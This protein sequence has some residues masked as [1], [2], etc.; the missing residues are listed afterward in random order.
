LQHLLQE[1]DV[2]LDSPAPLFLVQYPANGTSHLRSGMRLDQL[3]EF[4]FEYKEGA[5]ALADEEA[6]R[7]QE[8]RQRSQQGGRGEL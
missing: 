8:A 7:G 6:L 4:I 3:P 5:L 1:T 2:P